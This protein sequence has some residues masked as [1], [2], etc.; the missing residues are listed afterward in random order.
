MFHFLGHILVFT[1]TICQHDQT[2][3]SCTILSEPPFTPIIY[4]FEIIIIIIIII[5]NLKIENF[6]TAEL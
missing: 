2:L 3:V 5:N 1:Y 6:E 4:T